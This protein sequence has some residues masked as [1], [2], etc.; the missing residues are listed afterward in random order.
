[1]SSDDDNEVQP[2]MQRSLSMKER[3]AEYVKALDQD[4]SH[5]QLLC[6]FE[7]KTGV[8]KTHL[9]LGLL[10]VGFIFVII[11]FGPQLICNLLG[12][13]Y[14]AYRSFKA[15]ETPDKEDDTKMLLYWVGFAFF[16]II[17]FFSDLL[18]SY[19]PIYYVLKFIFIL[20]L[21]LPQTDGAQVLYDNVIVKFLQKHEETIDGLAARV[22]R[23]GINIARQVL[24]Q[25]DHKMREQ[26][27]QQLDQQIDQ[28]LD[29]LNDAAASL[30][31]PEQKKIQ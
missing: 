21:Q 22:Q 20:W 4:L 29:Q 17:E 6:L 9:I 11:G 10:A 12:F 5:S 26:A 1:M 25:A 24:D 28:Q 2:S 23:K 8:K 19:V 7:E 16:T 30:S 15:I 3:G 27:H 13:V 31:T 14:P 18:L